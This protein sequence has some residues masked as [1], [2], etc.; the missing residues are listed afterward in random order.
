VTESRGRVLVT[1]P[2][3]GAARTAE[4]LR[5]AGWQPLLAPMLEIARRGPVLPVPGAVQAVLVTSANA[6][7]A[8]D[9]AWHRK[10]LL[11]VGA[12]TA[13]AARAQGFAVVE[14]A[15]G[16]ALALAALVT[17][18]LTPRD[19]PLLLATAERQ[20]EMLVELL[21]AGGFGVLR[22]AVY[23]ARPVRRLPDAAT[24]AIAGRDLAAALFFS[25]ETARAFTHALPVRLRPSLAAIRALSLSPAVDTALA[26]LPFAS[27]QVA[28]C[29][30]AAALLAIL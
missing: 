2:E 6:L 18:R 23:T 19:G 17:Y 20:G 13:A 30:T 21:R 9:A 3:P 16:D 26:D 10:P 8:F 11:A 22:R 4:A 25:A 14:S 27:R 7:P 12:A 29:P 15:E 5:A 1:R 28:A 24:A